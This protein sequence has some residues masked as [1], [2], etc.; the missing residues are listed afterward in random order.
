MVKK[1]LLLIALLLFP[2]LSSA[3]NYT[4]FRENQESIVVVTAYNKKGEPLTEGTGFIASADGAVITNYHVIGIAKDIKIRSGIKVLDV[5]GVMY[6]DKENDFV[7]LRVKGKDLH[8]VK[9]GDAG[10]INSGEKVYI[11][12]SSKDSGNTISKGTFRRMRIISPGRKVVEIT[13]PVSHG[14]SGSPLFNKNGEVIG[15]TTFLIKRTENLILA[16]PADVIRDKLKISGAV[17][18]IESIIKN[19]RNTAEYWFYLGY[20]LSEV[21]AHKDAIDVF[22]E[23]ISRKPGFADARYYRG[24]AYENRGKYKEAARDY[25]EA[26]KLNADFADAHF[27]LGITYGKLAMYKEAV[28]VLK[29]AVRLEPDFADAYYNLGVAYGKLGMY[30][31]GIEAGKQAV[32]LKPDFADAHYNLG[33][34]YEKSASYREAASAFQKVLKYRPDYAEAHYNL[35]IVY[36]FLNDKGAALE[37]YKTLKTINTKL[38]DKLFSLIKKVG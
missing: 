9:F 15:M 13:A 19:Y 12:S 8:P 20:Y 35:G 3:D 4:V 17:T 26:I 36:L 37:K 33:I 24:V 21:G 27:S 16:M 28:E 22:T 2:S 32:M 25:R 31:E 5:E 34:A 1:F 7:I 30:K 14:S 38:A 11:I 23:A 6:A 29:Q 18:A 10:Q